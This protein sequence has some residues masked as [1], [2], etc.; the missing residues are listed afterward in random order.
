M[1]TTTST[2]FKFWARALRKL[3]HSK[4]KARV[5]YGKLVLVVVPVLQSEGRFY[6]KACS[7]LLLMNVP[8]KDFT[9]IWTIFGPVTQNMLIFVSGW[10]SFA[11]LSWSDIRVNST[12]NIERPFRSKFTFIPTFPLKGFPWAGT[13][14][15]WQNLS[16][17]NW[18][19]KISCPAEWATCPISVQNGKIL[20]TSTFAKPS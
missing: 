12:V 5:Q 2:S 20:L 4:P 14:E 3:A 10:H 1:R 19:V 9:V 11:L 15:F 18:H 16:L 13:N 7:I 8:L 6:V 17:A